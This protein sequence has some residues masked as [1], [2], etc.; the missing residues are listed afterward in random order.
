MRFRRLF[1]KTDLEPMLPGREPSRV[2]HKGAAFG[3][4]RATHAWPLA[5][6]PGVKVDIDVMRATL[7]LPGNRVAEFP[8]DGSA[9]HCLVEGTDQPGFPQR[10]L[11]EI[12]Q[13]ERSPPWKPV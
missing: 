12:E 6:G 11:G 4:D 2:P 13:F 9:R 1:C 10:Q 8:F 5:A 7:T 3:V